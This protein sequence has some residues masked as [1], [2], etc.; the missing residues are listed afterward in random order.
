M[1]AGL[2]T[3]YKSEFDPSP[4]TSKGSGVAIVL[5]SSTNTA[6]IPTVA[7]TGG[8]EMHLVGLAT[9]DATTGLPKTTLFFQDKRISHNPSN[10]ATFYGMTTLTGTLYFPSVPV[11]FNGNATGKAP[12]CFQI[13]AWQLAIGGHATL[14]AQGCE[15]AID[16]Q[17][18]LVE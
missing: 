4:C 16:G 17:P 11:I 14:T 9:A 5:T 15:P 7:V 12:S 6:S 2:I 3:S 18:V 10:T 1:N 13:I 8:A